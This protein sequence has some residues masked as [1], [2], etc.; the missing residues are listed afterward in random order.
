MNTQ[1]RIDSKENLKDKIEEDLQKYY[2]KIDDLRKKMGTLNAE[3][4]D[5]YQK[6]KHERQTKSVRN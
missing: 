4:T 2:R 5:L 1:E 3:L 6:L